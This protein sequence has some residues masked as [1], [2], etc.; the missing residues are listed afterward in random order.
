M[1][2]NASTTVGTTPKLL[3]LDI[4]NHTCHHHF[5]RVGTLCGE[6]EEGHYPLPY[7]YD[8]KCVP[9]PRGNSN[10]WKYMM[11][12]FLPLTVFYFI[13]VF[14]NI[15]ITSSHFYAFVYFSQGLSMPALNRAATA[16]NRNRPW[17]RKAAEGLGSVYGI[18][19]LDFFRYYNNGICLHTS[20]IET[21]ALDLIVG[22]Y[23]LLLM[24]LSYILVSLYDRNYR[25][26]LYI[27]KPFK[28]IFSLFRRNWEIGTSLIDAFATFFLLSSIKL[29]SACFDLLLPV[30][31]YQ[32]DCSGIL[33]YSWR[34]FYNANIPY[35]G[36]QH[37]YYGSL[38]AVVC[39]TFVLIPQLLLF[40]YPFRWFQKF[41]NLFPFRWYILHTFVDSFQGC[42]KD[43]TEPGTRDCR[44]FSFIFLQIQWIMFSAGGMTLGSMYFVYG[45]IIQIFLAI[46]LVNI[47]PFKPHLLHHSEVHIIFPLILSTWYTSF[48]G[49]MEGELTRSYALS[50]LLY[51]IT[52]VA[53]VVPLLYISIIILHWMYIHLMFGQQLIR[54]LQAWRRGYDRLE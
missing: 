17:L 25:V 45:A 34:L 16:S 46:L 5:H 35:F 52:A 48:L 37:K 27:W 54:R 28:L 51:T 36:E 12:A 26:L 49:G 21:L 18:W 40:L 4:N 32:L 3:R 31:V 22:I 14:L 23:P 7:S 41:L 2:E 8:M 33:K 10:W 13:I 9:C 44:W 19:S 39:I 29:I 30:K 6:C 47:E 38:A 20:T 24:A 42:Y 15:N 43:G 53:S 11:A 50:V 1:L